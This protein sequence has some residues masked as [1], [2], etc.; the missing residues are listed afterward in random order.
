MIVVG[1]TALVATL[2]YR[3]IRNMLSPRQ[4]MNASFDSLRLVNSYGAFG[5]VTR[6]RYEII[7]EGT[8]DTNPGPGSEWREYEFKGKPGDVCRR[9]RQYAPYHLRLDW[10]MWFAA[11]SPLYASRWFP[12]LVQK[13]LEGDDRTLRLLRHNP[14]RDGP[15]AFIR[16]RKYI[17]RYAS[18]ENRRATG[19]WW[20]RRPAGEFMQ[21]VSLHGPGGASVGGPG[22][23][24]KR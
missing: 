12:P 20:T 4:A 19:A 13:L 3:P 24:R 17:Y 21:A 2:G 5:S 23:P 8:G 1:V 15:P 16:A 14:F 7:I 6:I 18:R 11:L 10:L 9:A 22:G